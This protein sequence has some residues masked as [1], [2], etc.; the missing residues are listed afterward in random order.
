M[1]ILTTIRGKML[2]YILVTSVLIYSAAVGYISIYARKTATDEVK[3]VTNSYAL[4]YAYKVKA[5]LDADFSVAVTLAHLAQNYKKTA[6]KHFIKTYQETQQTIIQFHPEYLSVATSWELA[7]TDSL[8]KKPYGRKL[9][10]YYR[11]NNEIRSLYKELNMDGDII[12]S[13]YHTLKLSGEPS[14]FDPEFYSYSGRKEDEVINTNISVPIMVNNQFVG[15]AGIDI[16]MKK[17]KKMIA[18]IRP[19]KNSYAFLLTNSGCIVA[20]PDIELTGKFFDKV[21]PEM[22]NAQFVIDQI[23]VGN[24]FQFSFR[25]PYT[26][27]TYFYAFA[28]V[29]INYTKTPWSLVISVPTS[30]IVEKANQAFI[31][32]IIVGIL[33]MVLLGFVIF[34]IARNITNPLI[35]TIEVLKNLALGK[36]DTTSH[37]GIQSQDELGQMATSVNTLMDSLG[38]TA[39]FATQIG[40]G[41]LNAHFELLSEE[42]SIGKS[43]IEMQ[44]SLINAR[45]EEEKRKSEEEKQKWITTGIT[46]MGEI[47]R[48]YTNDIKQLSFEIVKNL[49]SYIDIPIGSVYILNDND[50]ENIYFEMT[51]AIAYGR[52]RTDKKQV[53]QGEGMI[54]R[55]A[56]EKETIYMID[57]PKN[58]VKI[59]SGLGTANPTC[60]LLVPL[61]LNDEVLG[62]MELASFHQLDKYKI[63][64]CERIGEIIASTISSVKMNEKTAA[65]LQQSR[66]QADMLAQQEEEMRQTMEEMHATQE[67]TAK[68]ESEMKA[69][70]DSIYDISLV[71]EFDLNG[72]IIEINS[73]FLDLLGCTR[74][75]MVGRYQGSF[76]DN[77]EDKHEKEM[78]WNELRNN[79]TQKKIQKILTLKGEEKWL[80]EIYAPIPD[81]NGNPYKVINIAVDITENMLHKKTGK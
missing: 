16:D 64:F 74:E 43:L 54:G 35:H 52:I 37:I 30:V 77:M 6:W 20:H 26:Q 3:E 21:H 75:Q 78:F 59:T 46:R 27:V 42:D 23:K 39:Q 49:I 51:A 28:P 69:I 56:F 41:N 34:I 65:L 67:E 44:K 63:E 36:I 10:G 5:D 24:N 81:A 38:R 66:E 57:V 48:S 13:N 8:W 45:E 71:A 14:I 80:S 72:K 53:I 61:K 33:G 40:K 11:E 76:S 47:L 17:F 58:Y 50:P 60:L 1:R 15:L 31:Y 4:E 68:R 55:C 62:V 2:F 73:N 9:M 19:F 22:N 79:N 70:I 29:L 25:D 32:S 12:G 7:K 18:D